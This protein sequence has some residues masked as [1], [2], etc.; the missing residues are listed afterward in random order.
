MGGPDQG[1]LLYGRKEMGWQRLRIGR[2]GRQL[3]EFAAQNVGATLQAPTR[4]QP[5]L[6]QE[7]VPPLGAGNEAEVSGL[8]ARSF[9]NQ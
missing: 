8:P 5:T 2:T 6:G 4:W 1:T 9:T 7:Q 3:W